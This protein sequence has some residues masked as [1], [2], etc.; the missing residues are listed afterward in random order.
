MS[1]SQFPPSSNHYGG[2][3]YYRLDWPYLVSV[4]LALPVHWIV[5]NVDSRSYNFEPSYDQTNLLK[6]NALI[7]RPRAV[8]SSFS[9]PPS[10]WQIPA[11]SSGR[12]CILATN[13]GASAEDVLQLRLLL[14]EQIVAPEG[15]EPRLM[16]RIDGG[17]C[18]ANIDCYTLNLYKCVQKT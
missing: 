10:S 17:S 9:P 13:V 3:A 14:P 18:S 6:H 12:C 15:V 1:D 8:R 7:R 5:E 4:G 2:Q 11:R 16:F